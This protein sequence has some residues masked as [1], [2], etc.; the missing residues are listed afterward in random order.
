MFMFMLLFPLVDSLASFRCFFRSVFLAPCDQV[1]SY[2]LF[3]ALIKTSLSSGGKWLEFHAVCFTQYL[4]ISHPT[5]RHVFL[6][7]TQGPDNHP[8]LA[9]LEVKNGFGECPNT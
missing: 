1:S 4:N 9:S 3:L 8:Q 2:L 5:P 6:N 7:P